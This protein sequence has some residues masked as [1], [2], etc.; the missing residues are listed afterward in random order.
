[1]K[2]LLS[3]LSQTTWNIIGDQELRDSVN[4]M[5]SFLN[6]D[7]KAQKRKWLIQMY[8]PC[9]QQ[10]KYFIDFSGKQKK[11]LFLFQLTILNSKWRYLKRQS[12]HFKLTLF[13]HNY[14]NILWK[15]IRKQRNVK[16]YKKLAKTLTCFSEGVLVVH[17]A[18]CCFLLFPQLKS[19]SRASFHVIKS[20][21]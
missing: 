17:L 15:N 19:I 3:V 9:K 14:K 18:Y 7:I 20:S 1:M 6:E 21:L 5:L 13:S 10:F 11:M 16:E 8:S 12:A 4:S 2:R